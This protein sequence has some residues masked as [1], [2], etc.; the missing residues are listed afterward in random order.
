MRGPSVTLIRW[1]DTPEPPC[2]QRSAR[3][4][5]VWA[6]LCGQLVP[7]ELPPEPPQLN[8]WTCGTPVVWRIADSWLL[9]NGIQWDE[10]RH[11]C[12]CVHQVQAD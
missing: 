2:G 10:R 11:P 8:V 12:V 9:E 3:P 5:V 7:I 4:E 6:K 1:A